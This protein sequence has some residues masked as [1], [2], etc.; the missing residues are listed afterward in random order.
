MLS[1]RRGHAQIV[2][3]FAIS[4]VLLAYQVILTRIFSVEFYPQIAF[5]GISL[6]MLGLTVGA[7]RVFLDRQD[8]T[9]TEIADLWSRSAQGFAL[10]GVA[11]VFYLLYLP[12]LLPEHIRVPITAAALILF[13]LPFGYGGHCVTLL[14]TKSRIGIGALY[15]GDLLG[16][17]LGCIGVVGLLFIFDPIT[18]V[19]ALCG[20]AAIAGWTMAPPASSVSRTQAKRLA[21][22]FLL[23]AAVQGSLYVLAMPH[24]GIAWS[25]KTND[26]RQVIFE[27]WNAISM[28]RVLPDT[29]Q[30]FGWGIAHQPKQSIS[31]LYLDIDH[32]A[33]TSITRFDGD[34]A[35]LSFLADDVINSGYGIRKI[36]DAAV[37]GVGGGR[38]ILSALYFGVDHVTGVELNPSIFEIL[39]RRF[40]DYSGHLD[41][42]PDVTLVE[43][44]AR[45]WFSRSEQRFDLVQ[46]SLI[47][48]W[49]TTA[50]GGLSMSED[51]LYTREGWLDFMNILRPDGMLT[52][53]RWYQA[54]GHPEEYL[55]LLS[56]AADVL[57]RRGVPSDDI[58]R[59]LIA[60]RGGDIVTVA[61]GVSPFTDL[62]IA[63]AH[64]IAN[65]RGFSI[66]L[67]PTTASDEVAETFAGG[68]ADT[69][70]YESLPVN[71]TAPTDDRPFFF[72]FEKL[73]N[74]P[75][76]KWNELLEDGQSVC[77]LML[78]GAV[79][80]LIGFVAVPL[81]RHAK[82][83]PT[84]AA[85]PQLLYF[86][87]IGLGFMLIEISQ[88]ERLLIFLGHPLYGLTVVLFTLLLFGGLGSA[89]VSATTKVPL[90]LRTA[91]TC[92]VI[93]AV[94]LTTEPLAENFRGAETPVRILI[95]FC[96]LAPAGFVMGTMFPIGML[97][98][99]QF[100]AL[101]PWLWGINGAAS[102]LAS[103]AA[104]FLS[105]AVGI[106]ATFWCGC[107]CYVVCTLL[108]IWM[109]TTASFRRAAE[110]I[111]ETSP[112]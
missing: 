94:G 28:V 41:R 42:R 54:A 109:E 43:D 64:A 72:E 82:S 38:D 39:T 8:R 108:T 30:P 96:L 92:L 49:A 106:A 98:S 13:T 9:D 31:Q 51:K 56:L 36:R 79:A 32:S 22:A 7:M 67:D 18:I 55:R 107:A 11:M 78:A 4:L 6:A 83:Y 63:K 88:M 73:G 19:F 105:I 104:V 85:L 84:R 1:L 65:E 77:A 5:F 71:L 80:V 59:H 24:L 20:I 103:F 102:V 60:L 100:Q 34:L 23:C 68:R 44:E 46:I 112:T 26:P 25:S 95:S 66:L 89:T 58:R 53:S 33:R 35:P 45:S 70:Y 17:A 15:A 10:S 91:A 81:A 62:E 99:R 76:D 74:T 40:G 14:L 37:V 52:V 50:A 12:L 57:H 97:L 2:G 75:A 29:Q 48:T 86:I 21:V 101:Q 69:A 90:W 61:V 3:I 111:P 87:S 47:D 16:A 93:A 110:A 27:R